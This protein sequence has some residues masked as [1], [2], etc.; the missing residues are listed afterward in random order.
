[1]ARA[2][3]V[4]RLEQVDEEERAEQVAV[5]EHEVLVELRAVLAV[6]AVQQFGQLG[7]VDGLAGGILDLLNDGF[8]GHV[9]I[10]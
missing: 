4:G 8:A 3:V 2:G 9:D 10:E 6:E 5:A 7:A 1:M